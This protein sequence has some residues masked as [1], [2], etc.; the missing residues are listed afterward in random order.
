MFSMQFNKSFPPQLAMACMME[1]KPQQINI[2]SAKTV[3]G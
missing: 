2:H 3:G 1:T